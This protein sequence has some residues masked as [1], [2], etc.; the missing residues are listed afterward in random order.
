MP[1]NLRDGL[2]DA[3]RDVRTTPLFIMRLDV[4]PLQ[5]IGATPGAYPRVGVVPRCL[6]R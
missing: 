5:V 1:I 3:L 2:L 6:R 4:R